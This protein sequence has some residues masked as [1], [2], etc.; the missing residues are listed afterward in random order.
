MKELPVDIIAPDT[1]RR[2][3]G[4]ISYHGSDLTDADSVTRDGV[5]ITTMTRTAFDGARWAD[6]LEEAVVFVDSM[7]AFGNVP[8]FDLSQNLLGIADLFD[9]DSGLVGEFDGKQHRE[10]RHHRKDNI[11]EEGFESANLVVVRSDKVDV[12]AARPQLVGRLTDGYRRGQ[13]RDRRWDR[14]ALT[15]PGWWRERR[16]G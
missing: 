4:Q 6:S 8:I 1:K 3:T 2:S 7:L 9:P 14:W 13:R 5:R 11:R 16:S 15:Q 10:A 12:R